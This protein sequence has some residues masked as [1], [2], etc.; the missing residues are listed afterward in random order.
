MDA[1]K[2]RVTFSLADTITH[3]DPVAPVSDHTNTRQEK[4]TTQDVHRFGP[5]PDPKNKPNRIGHDFLVDLSKSMVTSTTQK[6]ASLQL[7]PSTSHLTG[8][9]KTI[10]KGSQLPMDMELRDDLRDGHVSLFNTQPMSFDNYEARMKTVSTTFS[11]GGE[12]KKK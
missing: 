1:P 3:F 7:D 4:I 12:I 10:P 8:K 11:G 5:L 2:K 9:Y 6:G